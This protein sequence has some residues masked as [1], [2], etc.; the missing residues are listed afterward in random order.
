MKNFLI[1]LFIASSL[2]A[3]GAKVAVTAADVAAAAE[4]DT[5][6]YDNFF[7]VDDA[8]FEVTD[9]T[10]YYWNDER[11]LAL[12]T[13]G[14]DRLVIQFA[15]VA[16]EIPVG[17]WT[18]FDSSHIKEVRYDDASSSYTVSDYSPTGTIVVTGTD[19][20][21]LTIAGTIDYTDGGSKSASFYYSGSYGYFED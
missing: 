19:G 14:A 21:N 15:G 4:D 17:S 16:G 6:V 5:V 12:E 1:L 9:A 20:G 18:T 7:L 11:Y 2:T 8:P 3:C 10:I 13:S